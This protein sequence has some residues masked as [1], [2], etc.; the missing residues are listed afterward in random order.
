M[1]GFVSNETLRGK[2]FVFWV[3]PKVE[4][5]GCTLEAREFALASADFESAGVSV[6]GV[7]RDTLSAQIRFL[8]SH[9]L[10]YSLASDAGGA[11]LGAH[12]LIA[13]AKMY[14]KPVTKVA[15]TTFLVDADGMT[16]RVWEG[17][18]PLGHAAR[19]LEAI[20]SLD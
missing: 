13:G 11:W 17:V 10:P 1:R 14:G 8:Q 7:S 9:E 2:P 6:L 16:R 3:F 15:R 5:T 19:V 18:E 12:G 4:T 20:Q